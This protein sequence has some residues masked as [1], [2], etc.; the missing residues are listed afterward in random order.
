[1]LFPN[2]PV[3]VAGIAVSKGINMAEVIEPGT[4]A[5]G[6]LKKGEKDEKI[7]RICSGVGRPP[8]L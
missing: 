7:P 8:T 3:L 5:P 4:P 6:L 1:M 2:S